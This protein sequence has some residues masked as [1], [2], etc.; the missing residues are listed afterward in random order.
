MGMDVPGLQ[1]LVGMEGCPCSQWQD[2]GEPWS[3]LG[4]RAL[5][6]AVRVMATSLTSLFTSVLSSPAGLG[7]ID[8]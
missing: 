8:A 4:A 7:S 6:E 2:L 3:E 5:C 1:N